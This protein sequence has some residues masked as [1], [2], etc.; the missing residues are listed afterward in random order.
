MIPLAMQKEEMQIADKTEW[1]GG[2]GR[3]HYT[4]NITLQYSRELFTVT[5]RESR[6]LAPS[7][8]ID[9]LEY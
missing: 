3:V 9:T 8:E 6:E 1:G 2:G 4:Q 7:I 5:A